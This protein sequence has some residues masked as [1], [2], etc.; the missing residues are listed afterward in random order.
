VKVLSQSRLAVAALAIGAT[1]A[2]NCSHA[3]GLS[4][5]N[6]LHDPRSHSL[7][8][9]QVDFDIALDGN[10]FGGYRLPAVPDIV[11]DSARDLNEWLDR[12]T[13]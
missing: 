1:F 11:T 6:G 13:S 5:G 4:A 7:N 2:L 3:E 8:T 12:T 9:D 10:L